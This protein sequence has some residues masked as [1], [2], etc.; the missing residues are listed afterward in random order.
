MPVN[1]SVPH[2]R[3]RIPDPRGGSGGGV[4]A[5]G[6]APGGGGGGGTGSMTPG[7]P[8]ATIDG[9]VVVTKLPASTHANANGLMLIATSALVMTVRLANIRVTMV[10]T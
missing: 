4:A 2:R 9:A 3:S 7:G 10:R 6:A 5:A 1:K 8:P